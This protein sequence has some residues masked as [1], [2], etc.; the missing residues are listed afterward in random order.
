M[1]AADANFGNPQNKIQMNT[2]MSIKRTIALD[3]SITHTKPL[4]SRIEIIVE[5][6]ALYRAVFLYSLL[7]V[8]N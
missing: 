3:R 6:K 2:K 5:V 8:P 1:F 4:R 7:T